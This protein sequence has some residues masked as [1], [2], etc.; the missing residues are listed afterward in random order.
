MT[1]AM[2]GHALLPGGA[3]SVRPWTQPRDGST[4]PQFSHRLLEGK[5]GLEAT[6]CPLVTSHS[7]YGAGFGRSTGYHQILQ[8]NPNHLARSCHVGLRGTG[9]VLGREEAQLVPLPTTIN[10]HVHS[11][12]LASPSQ[13]EKT[14]STGKLPSKHLP[15]P[16]SLPRSE[17]Q[18]PTHL[19][20]WL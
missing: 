17:E 18:C 1:G 5:C 14:H 15:H 9:T 8:F 11:Q 4:P 7:K 16:Q 19:S 3:E 6:S 12:L 20:H 10:T 13:A 2:G